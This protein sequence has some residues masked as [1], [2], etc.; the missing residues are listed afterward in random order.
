[1][2]A[3]QRNVPVKPAWRH[4]LLL[5]CALF[6][7]A[8]Q[9]APA[10]LIERSRAAM[11]VDPEASRRLAER[12]LERLAAA[13]DADLQ[14]RAHLQ[15]CDYYSERSSAD[16]RREIER[17]R[18][19]LA[20]AKR[21]GLR[22]G[23]LICEGELHQY[24][25][26][27][28]QAM[29]LF[30]Q[31]VSVAEAKRDDEMLA[32]ALYQRGYLRGLQGELANG[33]ADLRRSI[34]LNEALNLP[35]RVETAVNSVAILYNRMGDYAHAREYFEASLRSQ[36][37]QGL[38]R[39]QVV[40]QHNLGRV[41]ENLQDWEAAQ[42]AF[43][44]VLA[45]S[46]EIGY[47]RGEAYA[48]RG[49]ASVRNAR[50][51]PAEALALLER[52]AEAQQETP[53]ERLRAQIMLQRGIALRGL[54]RS[55][56]S[57]AELQQ[58]LQIFR[59]AESLAEIAATHGALARSLA[60]AGDWRGAY[61]QQVQFKAAGD[62]LLKRQLDQRF[63]TL[64]VEFD[65]E[66]K[67]KE[68]AALHRENAAVERALAQEKRATTLQ[69]VV[70][71]LLGLLAILLA[72]LAWRQRRTGREM[73][74]LAMTDELTGLANRRHALAKL[75]AMLADPARRCAL[76]IV[77][78]DHFKSIN[79]RHGHLVG[80]EVLRAVAQTLNEV[81]REPVVIARLGGE[82]FVLVLPDADQAAALALAQRLLAQVRALDV[83]RWVGERRMSVSIGLTASQPGDSAGLM[84]RRADGALYGAKAAGRDRVVV[85][86]PEGGGDDP[87]AAAV[88]T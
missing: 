54:G 1:M 8:M 67:I 29:A 34:A 45:L 72:S 74:R 30:Q 86:P 39:E 42:R 81:V 31:A 71:V 47:R 13:P 18:A 61:E 65:T 76:L 69:A 87:A 17:A 70:L 15:L 16:A 10:A 2:A 68:N 49:L 25:G 36:Q 59:Q 33:L 12:A 4:L 28:V 82:E 19:L 62:A 83:G 50:E 63:A 52:A 6:P 23:V 24:A 55:G 73:Q 79:D 41:L 5:C 26:D 9:A 53:D 78:I 85:A 58:A 40:T 43:E 60:L 27:N 7:C 80:D 3:P 35:Q 37:A 84:L 44:S 38:T 32:E 22:A 21:T 56:A 11:R 48:L 75:D 20:Q 77:D 66:A 57:I 51:A 64:R 88:S 46:R 14:I